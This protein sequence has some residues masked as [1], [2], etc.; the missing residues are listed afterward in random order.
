MT[1]RFVLSDYCQSDSDHLLVNNFHYCPNLII[2]FQ[3]SILNELSPSLILE[4]PILKQ[5]LR[6]K[7]KAADPTFGAI[8]L[9]VSTKY[10][11]DPVLESRAKY[12]ASKIYTSI[13]QPHRILLLVRCLLLFAFSTLSAL[14]LFGIMQDAFLLTT[15]N[16]QNFPACNCI[17]NIV[18]KSRKNFSKMI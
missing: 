10:A 18:E 3:L 11:E 5:D 7:R 17:K 1:D 13:F 14:I 2:F 15:K 16:I 8:R 12:L 9:G 6:L 4:G